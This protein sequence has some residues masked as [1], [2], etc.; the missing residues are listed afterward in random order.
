[1]FRIRL[2]LIQDF[3]PSSMFWIRLNKQFG[4][5]IIGSKVDFV[6]PTSLKL[7]VRTIQ[8]LRFISCYIEEIVE[9]I[10]HYRTSI[11]SPEVY[12]NSN[13][14]KFRKQTIGHDK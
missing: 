5:K 9:A 10:Q 2:L 12:R 13:E 14:L 11:E 8:R 7:L 6:M 4:I 3:R 1:M